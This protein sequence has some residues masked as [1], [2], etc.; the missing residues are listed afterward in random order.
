MLTWDWGELNGKFFEFF[1]APIFHSVRII[2]SLDMSF[3][4][5]SENWWKTT[6]ECT[7]IVQNQ[8]LIRRSNRQLRFWDAPPEK[9]FRLAP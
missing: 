1:V 3:G 8:W 4:G 6:F 7:H 5:D 9:R 2:K